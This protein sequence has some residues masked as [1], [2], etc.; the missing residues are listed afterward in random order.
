MSPEAWVE[1]GELTWLDWHLARTLMRLAGEGAESIQWAIALLSRAVREGDVCLDLARLE[2]KLARWEVEHPLPV[3]A[4]QIVHDVG[5]SLLVGGG[6]PVTPLVFDS[7][8]RLYLRRYWV[9]E[10]RVLE[11][12]QQRAGRIANEASAPLLRPLVERVFPNRSPFPGDEPDWQLAA[13]LVALRRHLCVITGGPGTGKT[14]LVGR[15]LAVLNELVLRQG[16]PPLRV[17]L[18]A[19]TGKAAARL[20]Q[21]IGEACGQLGNWVSEE[22]KDRLPRE[23]FTIH[24]LLQ[25][26]GTSETSFRFRKDNPLLVDVVVVD[27]CSMV[28]LA[29]FAHL[30]AALP[31]HARLILLGDEHQLASVEAGAVL[32]DICKRGDP[33]R[34]SPEQRQW[35]VEASGGRLANLPA[36]D[37]RARP[38]ADCIVRLVRSY[39]HSESGGIGQLARAINAGDGKQAWQLL[40]EDPTGSVGLAPP[41][42]DRE[43]SPDLCAEVTKGFSAYLG[44]TDPQQRVREFGQYRVLC[45]HRHGP[46]GVSF[47]NGQ[48]EAA[49]AAA[50]RVRPTQP[51]YPG[52]PVLVLENDYRLR[53]FNGDLGIVTEDDRDGQRV[54]EVVFLTPEGEVRRLPPSRLP[55]HQ[56]AFAMTIHKSQGSEFEV[57]SVVLPVRESA[58]L[59]R[60]LLY[61]AVTRAKR[62]VVVHAEEEVFCRA[63]ARRFERSSG[64]RDG[65]WGEA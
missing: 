10:R 34:F 35:L 2:E 56:T 39:R 41:E 14:Y 5:K 59:T 64:L 51:W 63:V 61:T 55:R 52:R 11:D 32:G 1:A 21:A 45:P 15:I 12:L 31:A 54:V 13:A 53:L 24:R 19:P 49:L 36:G 47:L 50:G 25:P 43:L 42:K 30:L 28:D 17:A 27:E 9:Y 22:A 7:K 65:L 16:R 62:R 44:A 23:S 29:L 20:A 38:L 57:V 37:D 60:E 4:D 3:S 48:I 8:G 33:L 26:V 6:S 58:L 46:A 18:T 40:R